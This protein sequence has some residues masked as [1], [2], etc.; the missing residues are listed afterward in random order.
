MK[1]HGRKGCSS[2]R[3]VREQSL[4]CKHEAGRANWK[5]SKAVSPCNLAR[6][7]TPYSKAA[8]AYNIPK[9]HHQ[10][11]NACLNTWASEGYS[12]S[13]HHTTKSVSSQRRSSYRQSKPVIFFFYYFFFRMWRATFRVTVMKCVRFLLRILSCRKAYFLIFTFMDWRYC[14]YPASIW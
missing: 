2:R 8:P 3:T 5:W 12:H 13:N 9:Q 11:R 1:C 7:Y 6:W 14:K 4:N 10:L